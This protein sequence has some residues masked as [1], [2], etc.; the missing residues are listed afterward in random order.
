M[1]VESEFFSK[2]NLS[3]YH[4]ISHLK[5]QTFCYESPRDMMMV[6]AKLQAI[7]KMELEPLL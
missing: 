6:K 5:W 3:L 2:N 1:E 4:D 7:F